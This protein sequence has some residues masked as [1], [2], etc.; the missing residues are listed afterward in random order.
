MACNIWD[1]YLVK[2]RLYGMFLSTNE[3]IGK[4][5]SRKSYLVHLKSFRT[6]RIA[7]HPC[8]GNY[9]NRN[10]QFYLRT[11]KTFK[12]KV[13]LPLKTIAPWRVLHYNKTKGR[14]AW[15]A[16]NTPKNRSSPCLKK[17][18]LGQSYPISAENMGWVM[19]PTTIGKPNTRNDYQRSEAAQ[20]L[21]RRQPPT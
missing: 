17:L 14:T 10:T 18:R 15:Y 1:R 4:L 21:G 6:P 5:Y 7:D 13:T 2:I 19:P 11:N 9:F 3:R 12:V 16:R 8:F 20:S